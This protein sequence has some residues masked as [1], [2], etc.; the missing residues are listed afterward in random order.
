M[1]RVTT[2][3]TATE[4]CA[5]RPAEKEYTLKD[6]NGLYLL[7]KPNG[8]KILRFNYVRPSDKKHALVSFGSLDDMALAEA[9]KRRDEYRAM[10]SAGIDPQHHQQRQQAS[11]Q[12]RRGHTQH[13]GPHRQIFTPAKNKNRGNDS[14][15]GYFASTL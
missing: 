12:L 6:G 2:P 7:V 3:L 13:D 15:D 8:A 11:E 10:V 5:A 1:A 4:V 9:R 14:S